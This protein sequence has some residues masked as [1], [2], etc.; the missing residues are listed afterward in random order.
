MGIYAK[1]GHQVTYS[2]QYG[3]E[4]YTFEVIFDIY[5]NIDIRTQLSNENSP[6]NV[7]SLN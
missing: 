5:T 2:H 7:N 1:R 4:K 3:F 6:N